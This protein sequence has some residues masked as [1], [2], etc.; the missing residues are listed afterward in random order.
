MD[1]RAVAINGFGRIGRLFLRAL[2]E[3]DD[4]GLFEVV[5]IKRNRATVEQMAHLFKYDSVHGRFQGEVTW[6]DSHLIV[7]GQAIKVIGPDDGLPWQEL[8]VAIVVESSG[9][10]TKAEKAKAHLEAGAKKVVITAP[11]KGEGIAT[12][13]M[14]VN[15]ETYDPAK[16]HIISNASCTTN[17]L[18]P[19]AKVL[20]DSFGIQKGMMTTIHSYT[21]DQRLVDGSHANNY[22][23]RAA[24]LSMVPTTTGAAKAVALVIPQLKGKMNGMALRVPTPDVSVV[25]LT[26][27]PARPVTVEEV[28]DA[29]KEAS[30]GPLGRYIGYDSDGCV[31]ADFIHDC[32]S[33]IF[34]PEQ[35]MVVDGLVKV[36]AWYDNEWGY[37]CRCVDLVN[38]L[39]GKG[40]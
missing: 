25:D 40:L 37:S 11:G 4:Q 24:A 18:A 3:F 2:Y 7:N 6:D 39:I 34:A 29:I 17:C 1:K 19:I 36:F 35:T 15:E 14:G 30:Q 8:G 28:N 38:Y 9:A 26:F 31:S 20:Q 22:R 23:A 16:D 33:A 32:R 13:V 27:L 12:F 10:Y 5:A 21:G